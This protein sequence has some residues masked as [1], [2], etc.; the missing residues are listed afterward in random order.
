[1]EDGAQN[2][3][4]D[5]SNNDMTEPGLREKRE[6]MRTLE[7]TENEASEKRLDT[8]STKD[9]FDGS[10]NVDEPRPSRDVVDQPSNDDS[11]TNMKDEHPSVPEGETPKLVPAF[12]SG[13]EPEWILM[14]NDEGVKDDDTSEIMIGSGAVT[15][16]APKEFAPQ[17][18]ATPP[19]DQ[20]PELRVA[21]GTVLKNYGQK[22]VM[23]QAVGTGPHGQPTKLAAKARFRLRD[24]QKALFPVPELCDKRSKVYIEN[25]DDGRR[26]LLKRKG[27][28]YVLDATLHDFNIMAPAEGGGRKRKAW[29][30]M[31]TS[32]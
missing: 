1:M 18:Q 26:I 23:F 29:S 24:V 28:L 14:V 13:E 7:D 22:C 4:T 25:I 32:R 5:P 10:K 8:E 19:T 2:A 20:D 27:R 17:T 15:H 30:T 16:V 3:E 31:P 12:E 21:D 9:A 11:H 6:D